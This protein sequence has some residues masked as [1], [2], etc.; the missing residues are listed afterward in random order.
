MNATKINFDIV[1]YIDS[2]GEVVFELYVPGVTDPLYSS[3]VSVFSMIQELVEIMSWDKDQIESGTDEAEAAY[4]LVDELQ[5]C[6][7]YI[8]D[9]I[10]DVDE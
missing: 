9:H 1:H 2:D 6:I 5:D 10:K 4:E 3:S 8:N 7:D